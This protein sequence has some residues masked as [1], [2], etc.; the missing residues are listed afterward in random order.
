MAQKLTTD[1]FSSFWKLC[2][3]LSNESSYKLKTSLIKEYI[4]KKS[5][6]SGKYQGNLYLL[7]KFLL[8]GKEKR[9]YNVKDK[10]LLKYFSQIF[11]T[12]LKSMTEHLEKQG[13]VS[14]T[15]MDFFSKSH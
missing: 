3:R 9:I 12:D 13:V 8:P 6:N 4:T 15:V 11:K 7:A 14:D 10:Q 5:D 2:K 1:A